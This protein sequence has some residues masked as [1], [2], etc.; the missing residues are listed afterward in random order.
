MAGVAGAACDHAYVTESLS[1]SVAEPES[2]TV[3]PS[4]T[5]WSPPACTVG[6]MSGA[7]STVTVL[8]TSAAGLPAASVQE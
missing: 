6:G 4:P 7:A 3:S 8:D 5:V 2:V 1:G